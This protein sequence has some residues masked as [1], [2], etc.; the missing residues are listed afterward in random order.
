M[1]P[2]R[3]LM[4]FAVDAAWQAGKITL[5]YFQT[6]IEAMRKA[7]ASPVTIADRRAEERL[8]ELIS[9]RFPDD[10][11]LGEEFGESGPVGSRRR[12]ILDPIDGTVSFV[13][14][15]PLYGVMVALEVDGEPAVG[16]VNFPALGE[17]VYAAR[18]EGCYWNGRRA[19]VSSEADLGNAAVLATDVTA[20]AAFG[21]E[22]AYAGLRDRTRLHRTWGDC[23]GHALVATGRAEVMLDP[24]MN[25][26]DTAALMP[27]V[28]EAGGTFTDWSGRRTYLAPE[29]V[30][31]NGVLF[32]R[33]REVLREKR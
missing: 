25:I 11:I 27:I 24:I 22:A 19:R 29:A 2:L 8:R 9:A 21:R 15:V 18:G 16:V 7:D 5:E 23:Y 3:D 32:E 14:G 13:R 31:T 1:D 10:A 28:E 30:S 6:P 33:V 4:D 17:I 12:W 20:M 26:W